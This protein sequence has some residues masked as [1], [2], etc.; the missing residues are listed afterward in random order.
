MDSS[1]K[2]VQK[3][4]LKGLQV[5][6]ITDEEI[7]VQCTSNH[8]SREFKVPLKVIG[9]NSEIHR[10]SDT[11]FLVAFILSTTLTVLF[12]LSL[13]NLNIEH[14]EAIVGG[15]V[16]STLIATVSFFVYKK[17]NYNCL[18]YYNM[19]SR[20]PVLV[21]WEDKPNKETFAAFISYF[22]NRLPKENA[23]NTVQE[24]GMSREI[25]NLY[26][27]W[28]KGVLSEEEFKAGKAKLLGAEGED[29][30]F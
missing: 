27:L 13:F 2:L 6:E 21:F 20:Q 8:Q 14:T 4:F 5:F 16:F 10:S 18:I 7:L 9:K 23:G 12:V 28:Q 1:T 19:F 11:K 22:N 15:L 29:W 17:R 25:Y 24:S 26:V 3:G 30:K